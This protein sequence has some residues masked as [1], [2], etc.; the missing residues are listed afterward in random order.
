MGDR[1]GALGDTFFWLLKMEQFEKTWHYDEHGRRTYTMLRLRNAIMDG[2]C[3]F[4][5]RPPQE[6][7]QP[8]D[9]GMVFFFDL[10]YR[11]TK[12]NRETTYC[13]SSTVL[14]EGSA[15]LHCPGRPRYPA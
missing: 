6:E 12:P 15:A 3:R 13:I 8:D 14:L 5:P 2:I 11:Y 9:Q 1:C 4:G 7:K 10:I